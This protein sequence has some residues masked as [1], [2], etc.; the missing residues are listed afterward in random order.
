MVQLNNM[1]SF[2]EQSPIPAKGKQIGPI[3]IANSSKAE[4]D[5]AGFPSTIHRKSSCACGGGCPSCQPGAGSLKIS[6]PNDAAEIEADAIADRVMRMTND[7]T[8]SVNNVP[9]R[10]Y[11]NAIRGD[12]TDAAVVHRQ[13]HGDTE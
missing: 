7:K 13:A 9:D 3:G 11:D 10:S 5:P 6:Q 4:S 2:A 1:R 12:K 8:S